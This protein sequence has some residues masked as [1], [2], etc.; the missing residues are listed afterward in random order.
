MLRLFGFASRFP[1]RVAPPDRRQPQITPPTGRLCGTE[2]FVPVTT[3]QADA[4]ATTWAD[5]RLIT[6]P[7]GSAWADAISGAAV[8]SLPGAGHMAN[9]EQP[10]A[11]ADRLAGF[12]TP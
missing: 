10:E 7:Y 6:E 2:G 8:E 4:G 5:D 1:F 12:L 11:L 9:L 3:S